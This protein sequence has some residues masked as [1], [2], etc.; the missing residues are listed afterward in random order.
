M[1]VLQPLHDIVNAV[2]HR[3]FESSKFLLFTYI[4]IEVGDILI[5][6]AGAVEFDEIL[7]P[8]GLGIQPLPK[9]RDLFGFPSPATTLA[10]A[11]TIRG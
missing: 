4:R 2:I 5:A 6:I 3:P 1:I 8:D 9:R 7:N 10:I 11:F